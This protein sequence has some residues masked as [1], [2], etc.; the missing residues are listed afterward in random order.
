MK[1]IL[2]A[3]IFLT[4]IILAAE[5]L[6]GLFNRMI[7]SQ[8]KSYGVE[9]KDEYNT[10]REE[11]LK[12]DPIKL[13]EFLNG[14]LVDSKSTVLEKAL[15]HILLERMDKK[16]TIDRLFYIG[17]LKDDPN[18]PDVI[19]YTP[20]RYPQKWC[21][22]KKEDMEMMMKEYKKDEC[23]YF[24]LESV[25]KYSPAGGRIREF[26][27]VEGFTLPGFIFY[28][29][30][31][32]FNSELKETFTAAIKDRL[33]RNLMEFPEEEAAEYLLYMGAENSCQVVLDWAKT[34]MQEKSR[35]ET[36]DVLCILLPGMNGADIKVLK[37]AKKILDGDTSRDAENEADLKNL[38]VSLIGCYEKGVSPDDKWIISFL[39]EANSYRIK[40]AH[41]VIPFLLKLRPD[42]E[43]KIEKRMKYYESQKG[44]LWNRK[45]PQDPD[46]QE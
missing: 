22:P 36:Y 34:R 26:Q 19:T 14:K 28:G 11:I 31:K 24:I 8:G 9:K 38:L 18:H 32:N 3:V 10:I 5:E 15:A 33:S 46:E 20:V 4:G 12:A 37:A 42:M 2:S 45:I 44:S 39:D 17:R 6:P 13:R 23:P 29:I 16:V 21:S 7:N 30:A 41:V 40:M 35:E 43:A 1:N 27:D 25:W